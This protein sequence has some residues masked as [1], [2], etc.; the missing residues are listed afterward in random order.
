MKKTVFLLL[1]LL[2]TVAALAACG[3]DEN[4]ALSTGAQGG[5]VP[6]PDTIE[7]DEPAG[8]DN[9]AD[10]VAPGD[11]ETIGDTTGGTGQGNATTGGDA[12]TSAG[13]GNDN[14]ASGE[15]APP[16]FLNEW[17][18]SGSTVEVGGTVPVALFDGAQG[19]TYIV[20]AE[21]LQVYRFENAAAAEEAIGTVS[22]DGGMIGNVS[23]RWAGP[24]HFYRQG[25][26][27]VFYVGDN[28]TTINMLTSALGQPA[29]G[30][31]ATE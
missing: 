17:Q 29:A 6:A 2:L 4:T 21:E 23:M 12:V 19:Q 11:A 7:N 15:A 9:V 5:Q 28:A 25:D 20:D 30:G 3:A 10:N 16:A 27:I 14:G 13:E 22:S 24:P 18:S 8:N 31:S 26:L 1:I